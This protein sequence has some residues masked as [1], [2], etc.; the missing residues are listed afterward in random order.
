MLSIVFEYLFNAFDPLYV[1]E[2]CEL[3]KQKDKEASIAVSLIL[4][5]ALGIAYVVK[6][7]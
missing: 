1:D 6:F 2:R 5:V 3:Q 4:G 7:S